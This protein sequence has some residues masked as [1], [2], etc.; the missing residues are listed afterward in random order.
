MLER[1]GKKERGCVGVSVLCGYCASCDAVLGVRRMCE[2]PSGF[3]F[4]G[5][6]FGVGIL[7]CSPGM[8]WSSLVQRVF[9]M[10]TVVSVFEIG[11]REF[12]GGG[13]VV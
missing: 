7:R 5:C 13:W 8:L 6:G 4:D 11:S 3:E 1:R 10:C 9:S 12:R 2:F